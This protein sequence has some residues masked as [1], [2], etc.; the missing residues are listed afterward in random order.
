MIDSHCHLADKQFADDLDDVIKRAHKAG[1]THMV[2]IADSLPEAEKC[3]EIAEKHEEIF[4]SVGVH[5]HHAKDWVRGDGQ[6]LKEM[7]SGSTKVRAIGEIGL[8]YHYD[9]S[10]RP[11]QRAVFLEQLTLSRELGL[12]AV[13]HCREAIKD[14]ETIVKEVEPLQFVLHC[15]TEKW[16]DIE[17]LVNLGHFLSFTGITT[18]PKSTEIREVIVNCPLTQM[19]IETDA[20]YLAPGKHRGK[21]NEPALVKEVLELVA[22]L[23][24]I[25]VE[26]ADA[27][28]TQN[29]LEFFAVRH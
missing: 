15:C 29:T 7:V 19:M 25:S 26:E 2:T 27:R 11:I 17:W 12:P 9:H 1:V 24:G 5:P 14:I 22:E 23:K 16:E 21:R 4:C 18:Y 8:D 3:I 20:P 10:P 13:V 28:I 6:K